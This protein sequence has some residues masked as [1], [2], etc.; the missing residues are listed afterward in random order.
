[1]LWCQEWKHAWRCIFWW[2]LSAVSLPNL[3]HWFECHEPNFKQS[4]SFTIIQTTS[5]TCGWHPSHNVWAVRSLN[6]PK[7]CTSAKCKS[8]RNSITW[9]RMCFTRPRSIL[10]KDKPKGPKTKIAFSTLNHVLP[11]YMFYVNRARGLFSQRH[12]HMGLILCTVSILL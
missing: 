4:I 8:C 2:L 6:I 10:Q 9:S 7:Q 12:S 5:K 11:W 1:M 3:C